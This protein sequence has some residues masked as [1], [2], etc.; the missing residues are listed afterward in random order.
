MCNEESISEL[1]ETNGVVDNDPLDEGEQRIDEVQMLHQR[2][3]PYDLWNRQAGGPYTTS[4]PPDPNAS[5]KPS[6]PHIPT[7]YLSKGESI[8]TSRGEAIKDH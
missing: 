1:F 4:T 7:Q 8:D 6:Y 5:N 3:R 2:T